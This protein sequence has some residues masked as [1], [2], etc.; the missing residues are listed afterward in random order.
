MWR[1][2]GWVLFVVLWFAIG[3]WVLVV[4]VLALLV[5]AVRRAARPRHPWWT[6]GAL[7]AVAARGHRRS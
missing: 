3:P 2:L 4:G 5:P 6:A 7:V 1:V